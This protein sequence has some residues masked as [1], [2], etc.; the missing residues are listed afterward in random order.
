MSSKGLGSGFLTI[1]GVLLIA[2]SLAG[3]GGDD[4]SDATSTTGSGL[5]RGPRP[6]PSAPTRGNPAAAD[7]P[8]IQGVAAAS[9]AVGQTYSFQPAAN[10]SGNEVLTFMISN[11]PAWLSFNATTGLLSGTPTAS[12]VGT[13]SNIEIAVT[14][15]SSVASL[16]SFSI[17]VAATGTSPGSTSS[18]TLSW[19]PPTENSNGTPLVNLDGYMVYYGQQAGALTNVV[20]VSNP[21]LTS[22][23]VQNLSPGTYYFAVASVNSAG[24]ESSLSSVVST[25]ID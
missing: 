23:V 22:Y 14:D 7:D 19:E 9:V 24:V 15:G 18:V 20:N 1:A 21:G 10:D 3:C 12:N 5:V 13:Y 17:T 8:T 2:S 11:K 25:T 16:P 4:S 6:D